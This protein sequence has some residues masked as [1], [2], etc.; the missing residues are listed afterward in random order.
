[1]REKLESL[2]VSTDTLDTLDEFVPKCA[3]NFTEEFVGKLTDR[4]AQK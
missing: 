2:L 3:K 4:F 1:M